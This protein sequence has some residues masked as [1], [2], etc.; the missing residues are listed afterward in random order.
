MRLGMGKMGLRP[1]DFWDYSFPEWTCAAEGFAEFHG[2]GSSD[3]P[4]LEEIQKTIEWDEARN[5]NSG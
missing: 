2:G 1:A 4:T 5:G 3:V